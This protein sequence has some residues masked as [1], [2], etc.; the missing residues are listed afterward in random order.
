MNFEFDPA[1]SPANKAKHGIDFE[2]A[3]EM[4][5]DADAI[6][7]GARSLEEARWML[8][9]KREGKLWTA[10]CTWRGENVRIISVRRARAEEKA[11]YEQIKDENDGEES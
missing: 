11:V 3:Q 7:G 10:I 8:I 5:Q 4:W 1:K 6:G 2:A 9:A